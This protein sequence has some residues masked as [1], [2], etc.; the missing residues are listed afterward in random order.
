MALNINNVVA[1]VR[2]DARQIAAEV[3]LVGGSATAI[4]VTAEN[5]VSGLHL[6]AGVNVALVAAT[7][8]V[9][10]VVLEAKR[11]AAALKTS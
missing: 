8:V 10:A 2:A 11:I 9:S 1:R 6:P 7:G 3:A 4:L 5:T